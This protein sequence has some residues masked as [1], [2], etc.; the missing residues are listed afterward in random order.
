[1]F[2]FR[3]RR[4][5]QAPRSAGRRPAPAPP[6]P[7]DGPAGVQRAT[8]AA[9]C[10]WGV[11]AAFRRVDGVLR[12]TAGYTG[13]HLAHP[14]YGQVSRHTT[15]HAEAVEVWFDPATVSY[16][17]LLATF[18]RIHNPTTRRRQGLDFGRQYR[19]E[20]FFHDARQQQ[21]A[22][23]SRDAEQ[24]QLSRPITTEIT[25]ASAFYPAEE[26]HQRYL[27]KLGRSR[28]AATIHSNR[29]SQL[30]A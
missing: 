17:Q 16:G 27:E 12:T 3:K 4:S 30:G 1:M 7:G 22:A 24:T 13:G 28:P 8:F 25:A 5:T 21:Q 23:A 2:S 18:W 10:F 29:G 26:Y 20:I 9:G 14:S 6:F 11:E 19:S 15:G